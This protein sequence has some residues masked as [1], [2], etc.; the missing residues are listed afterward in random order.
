MILKIKVQVKP[1]FP[2]LEVKSV[3][4]GVLGILLP[5]NVNGRGQVKLPHLQ[6]AAEEA[7][8]TNYSAW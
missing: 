1:V 3:H 5:R 4:Y 7:V 8:Q 6:R 2:K